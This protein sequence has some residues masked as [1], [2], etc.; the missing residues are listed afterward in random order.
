MHDTLILF[1]ATGDLAHRYIFLSL[2]HLLRDGLLPAHFK[3]VAV[4]RQAHTNE[5]FRLALAESMSKKAGVDGQASDIQAMIARTDYVAADLS[6]AA[7][8]ARQLAHLSQSHCVSFLATPPNLFVTIAEGLKAAGLLQAPSRL[9]LE[10]PIG[11]DLVSAKAINYAINALVDEDRVYRID[12]YLGKAPVQNLLALRFGN[13]LLEAVWNRQWIKSV[14]ILVAET[15]GVDGREGYYAQYGALRDMVQNHMLQLLSL[16]AMEP[17]ASL[18]ADAV[19]DEKLKVLRALRP[20]TA[21]A[22]ALNTARGQYSAGVVSG[23]SVKGFQLPADTQPT[24]TF[25]GV[26][27]YIDNWRWADVPFRLATGKRLAER[28]TQIVINFRP[29]S[30]WIFEK[31]SQKQA[32]PNRM[33]IRLQPEENIELNFM[34]SLAGP[35]WG[36]L[37]LQ[38]LPLNLSMPLSPNRRIAYER[39][40]LDALHGNPALFVRNDEI[41]AA[42]S[43]I[44]S[45]VDAW[46]ATNTPIHPYAAGSWGPDEADGLLLHPEAS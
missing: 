43:W 16:I 44:D 42:W 40:L 31:P 1:G 37:E 3:I 35:E 38:P 30:H 24:E 15:A 29:V 46:Q 6:N 34:S 10:K 27:A 28:C 5:S 7:E 45:I 22:A 2:A 13:T 9:V 18:A 23:K 32:T 17:P 39:L 14:D 26:R 8:I 19:R 25:V 12:H 36:A 11:R 33:M 41:E 20:M 21:E 4:A